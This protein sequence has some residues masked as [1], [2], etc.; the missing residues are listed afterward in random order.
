[1]YIL[2]ENNNFIRDYSLEDK[3]NIEYLRH[4]WTFDNTLTDII[5]NK[6]ISARNRIQSPVYSFETDRFGNANGAL[7]VNSHTYFYIGPVNGFNGYNGQTTI[8]YWFKL[9]PNMTDYSKTA[10]SGNVFF[11]RMVK[12]STTTPY[13]NFAAGTGDKDFYNDPPYWNDNNWHMITDVYDENTQFRR[14]FID[15]KQFWRGN[16]RTIGVQYGINL[17]ADNSDDANTGLY[18]Y[19]LFDDFKYWNKLLSPEEVLQEYENNKGPNEIPRPLS[20]IKFNNNLND[21][22]GT[23]TMNNNGVSYVSGRYNEGGE[24]SSASKDYAYSSENAY[25]YIQEFKP[26]SVSIWFKS[27]NTSADGVVVSSLDSD[28]H[29]DG[30]QIRILSDGRLQI[31]RQEYTTLNGSFNDNNWHHI[32][33]GY[34]GNNKKLNMWVDGIKN[35]IPDTISNGTETFPLTFGRHGGYD[36]IYFNGTIDQF[37]MYDY[38]ITDEQVDAL[39]NEPP[40]STSPPESP[41]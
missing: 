14:V 34:D 31:R 29:G 4:H 30:F 26:F 19:G 10:T 38:C 5:S 22:M 2:R 21:E 16:W 33:V 37:R 20:F 11:H 18:W 39:F 3:P 9:D 7:F 15:G 23:F 32:V 8:S 40:T 1:M 36:G 12:W 17:G 41:D 25:Q 13:I 28:G 35:T 6:T 27:N 24:F